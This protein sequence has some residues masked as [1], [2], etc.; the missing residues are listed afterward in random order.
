MD[1]RILRSLTLKSDG[2]L[3]CDDSTGYGLHLG[4][5]STKPGWN[6]KKV[7]EGPVWAHVRRSFQEGRVP[8]PGTCEE[9]ELLSPGAAPLDTLATSVVVRVEPTLSCELRCPCCGR[10]QEVRRRQGDWHLAPALFESLLKSCTGLG[11]EVDAVVYLGLGEPLEHPAFSSLCE[12]ASKF[13]PSAQQE[14]TTNGNQTYRESVGSGRLDRIIVSCDGVRQSSYAKYRIRGEVRR[15]LQFM[16]DVRQYAEHRP[17]L[18]W[19]YI[20]FEFNDSD[21]EIIEA[22][23]TAEEIGVDSI[24]FIVTNSRFHSKRFL[25]NRLFSF[26]LASPIA[27]LSPAAAMQKVLRPGK[28]TFG[29]SGT[30]GGPPCRLFVDD[31]VLLT[32]GV[33]QLQGWALGADGSYVDRIEVHLGETAVGSARTMHRRKDV[34]RAIPEAAGPYCGFI[35]QFPFPAASQ[36]GHAI[37][38]AWRYGSDAPRGGEIAFGLRLKIRVGGSAQYFDG[39]ASFPPFDATVFAAEQHLPAA[40]SGNGTSDLVLISIA[41]QKVGDG[42]QFALSDSIV[43]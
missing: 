41:N 24:M 19:K 14:L 17:F 5:V 26:P 10:M 30:P 11:I 37:A 31:C 25:A 4:E 29:L 23:T 34:P 21:E 6:I 40:D 39:V 32:C 12:L 35:L 28:V 15:A 9:C 1:C 36:P 13:V 3:C 27:S 33:V 8:W 22:Q 43:R 20:L 2:H 42:S 18:E 38:L 16:R 7:F